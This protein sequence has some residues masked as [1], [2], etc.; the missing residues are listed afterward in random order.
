MLARYLPTIPTVNVAVTIGPI[1][2][3][4]KLLNATLDSRLSFDT[5]ISALF[6]SCF[7][8]IWALRLCQ[9]FSLFTHK[10]STCPCQYDSGW[11]QRK[12]LET[13]PAYPEDTCSSGYSLTRPHQHIQHA[14]GAPL[15]AGQVANRIQGRHYEIQ[16]TRVQWTGLSMIKYYV[17]RFM[18]HEAPRDHLPMTILRNIRHAQT[19]ELGL[20]IVLPQPSGT[21]YRMTSDVLHPFP[22]LEADLKHTISS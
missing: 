15:A 20:F 22:S 10:M 17:Q 7:F 12:E 18:D 19:L 21:Q 3:E 8:N 14:E 2:S 11:C 16:P 9:E 5:R 13:S 1:S 6:K 4:V